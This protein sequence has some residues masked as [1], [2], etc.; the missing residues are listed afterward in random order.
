MKQNNNVKIPYVV[1]FLIHNYILNKFKNNVLINYSKI[2][3]LEYETQIFQNLM[4]S[5]RHSPYKF[6]VLEHV[7]DIICILFMI[8]HRLLYR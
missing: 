1:K 2:F 7:T 3:H 5:L 8:S 4:E 6:I